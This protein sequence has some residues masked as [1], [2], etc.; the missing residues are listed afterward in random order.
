VSSAQPGGTAQTLQWTKIHQHKFNLSI[1]ALKDIIVLKAANTIL[2]ITVHLETSVQQILQLK[3][4][5]MI[6]LMAMV[7]SI[8]SKMR[9]QALLAKIVLLVIIVM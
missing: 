4:L 6:M 2:L 3:H 1:N 7:T 8:N 9:Q 5:V